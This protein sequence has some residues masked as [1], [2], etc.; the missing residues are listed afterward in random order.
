[1]EGW[2]GFSDTL[3][4][5]IGQECGQA[6]YLM[7]PPTIPGRFQAEYYDLGGPGVAYLELS[8]Q[9]TGNG[10]RAGEGVD[11]GVSSDIGGGYQVE[12]M[13]L[14][15]WTEYTVRVTRSGRYR[16]IARMA[17]T[18]SGQLR[19]SVDGTEVE[20][21]LTYES[22]N[23]TSFHRNA[24]LDGIHLEEGIRTLRITH[25]AFGAFINWYELQLVSATDVF[26]LP[27]SPRDDVV[28]YPN[29]FRDRLFVDPG[30]GIMGRW[31][32]RLVDMT[33]RTVWSTTLERSGAGNGPIGI[34]VPGTLSQGAYLLVLQSK[35]LTTT[36]L[37]V[38]NGSSTKPP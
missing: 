24:V 7:V 29:P 9:N 28:V 25:D 15:E 13:T 27:E 32:A 30:A 17:A 1:S 14:R 10:I 20:P 16:M 37:V 18:R 36:H 8:P 19:L 5:R 12:N 31:R 35:N 38:R 2:E 3:T 6:P 21:A 33:G 22:T 11:I 26:P 34:D 4:V 23:S